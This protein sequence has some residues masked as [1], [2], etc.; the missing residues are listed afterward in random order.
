MSQHPTVSVRNVCK[1]YPGVQALRDIS[2]EFHAGSCHALIGE[3]GAGKSTLGKIIAGIEQPDSGEILLRNEIVRFAGPLQALE[4][5]I[6]VVHQE[7]AF[8]PNLSVAENLSLHRLPHRGFLLDRERLH[9]QAMRWLA[10]IAPEI[11][12]RGMMGDLPIGKQQLVQIAGAIGR[13]ASVLIFDEPTS[14]LSQAESVR[15]LELIGLLKS[16][17]MTCIYVSHRLA[18]VFA[19]CDVVTVLRDGELVGSYPIG[20]L[21]HNKLV[22]LMIGRELVH[23]TLRAKENLGDVGLRVRRLSS[24]GR[25]TDVSVDV[26]GGEIVGVAGLVG[27]GRTE[28]LEAIFGLDPAATGQIELNG[29]AVWFHSPH[30]AV[31][32]GLGLIPEDR[33]LQGLVL[34]LNARENVSLSVLSELANAGFVSAAKERSVV[35]GFFERLRIR[36][37]GLDTATTS[38]SGGNQQKL[39]LAKWLAANCRALLVD[40]PTRGVDVGAKA[41]IHRLI[42]EFADH[43]RPVLLVSSDLPELL[44][45]SDRIVVMRSGRVADTLAA[46]GA[47]EESVMRLMA[48]VAGV[49]A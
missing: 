25:F 13:G 35:S 11:D 6:G 48:G 24:P 49:G 47:T 46:E 37:P 5:G 44:A 2:V 31:E 45:I 28:V 3:N 33:K 23:E 42:R 22:Q 32:A 29:Q 40:E 14:S 34:P 16:Q 21:D 30:D 17:G 8:C 38:L 15:L 19:I 41:E 20:E 12:P 4:S 43:G 39:V 36:S 9:D 26:R 18:E 10:P 7:L 27:A 1:S